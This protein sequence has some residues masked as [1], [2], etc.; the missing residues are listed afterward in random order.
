MLTPWAS[1]ELQELVGSAGGRIEAKVASA[2]QSNSCIIFGEQVLLKLFRRV[3]PGINPDLEISRFFA[4]HEN[5]DHVPALMGSLEYGDSKGVPQTL[6]VLHRF[7]PGAQ[8]AWEFTLGHVN[9]FFSKVSELPPA[10]W[11][12][13]DRAFNAAS[14]LSS[15]WALGTAEPSEQARTLDRG[16]FTA[17]RLLGRRTAEM[18]VALASD[19][20]NPQFATEPITEKHLQSRRWSMRDLTSRT[21]ELLSRRI[22]QLPEGVKRA[23]EDVQKAEPQLLA[24]FDAL[25]AEALPAERIRCHGDYHL[26]QVLYARNDFII[27]D[28]EGEPARTLEERREKRSPLYDVA[29]MLRSL[30]YAASQGYFQQ[31]ERAAGDAERERALRE[32]AD[33]WYCWAAAA[34]FAVIGRLPTARNFCRRTRLTASGCSARSCWKR[35]FMNWP[36][37]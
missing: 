14:D 36:M 3:A 7:I 33:V 27:I 23:A 10:D 31:R 20:Q 26:G 15:T 16:F 24:R 28:F 34:L 17:A 9:Q 12:V 25:V 19:H 4:E 30:H 2:D 5:F 1:D 29:G 18:H 6:G 13:T 22:D 35:R 11:P 32:A 21:C 8:V 37:N